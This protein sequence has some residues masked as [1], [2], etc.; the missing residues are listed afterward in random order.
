MTAM[1]NPRLED[2]LELR[3]QAHALGLESHHPVNS[4]L[5][6]LYASMFRG[7]GMN[8][9]E[10][11]EYREGDE[12]RNMDWRVTARTGVPH[13]KI[14]REERQ[15]SVIL[16]VDMGEHMKFGTR[17]CFKSV[18]AA[19]TAALLGWAAQINRDRVGGILFG[20]A[21]CLRYYRPSIER[22]GLWRI[23]R[24]LTEHCSEA[25]NDYDPM[26]RAL[27]KLKHNAPTGSLIMLVADLNRSPQSL[28]RHLLQLSQRHDLALFAIDDPA[29]W[30]LPTMGRMIFSG[31]DGQRVEI[32]TDSPE[33]RARYQQE[34]ESRRQSLQTLCKRLGIPLIAISTADDVHHTLVNGLRRRQQG[35]GD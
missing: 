4:V 7:Q 34:W 5:A 11:R 19:R 29:E 16:C 22:R 14:F 23:L 12:I 17:N 8:F 28:E 21:E 27:D 24:G 30:E 18:Q 10:V 3:H 13:L 6:G 2:L 35:L 33:G 9:E 32:N 20:H 15:R 25:N 31:R 1:D 26:L